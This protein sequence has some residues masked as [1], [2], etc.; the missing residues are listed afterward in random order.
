MSSNNAAPTLSATIQR[1]ASFPG[2]GPGEYQNASAFAIIKNNGSVVTWG[3]PAS[4]GDSSAVAGQLTGQIPV[5]QIVS[6]GSAFAALRN[7]GSVIT[8]GNPSIGGDS[9]AVSNSLSGNPP[10]TQLFSTGSAFAALRSDGSVVSWGMSGA[11]GDSSNIASQLNGSIAVTTIYSTNDAFAALRSDGSVVTWGNSADGGTASSQLTASIPVIRIF[12]TATAF[13][14]LRADGSVVT[15]GDSTSGGNNSSVSSQLTGTPPV[16]QVFS[17]ADAFAALRADGS[18]ITWG[19]TTDGGNSSTVSTQLNGSIPV[20]QVYATSD[21]FIALRSD[22]SIVSWGNTGNIP[23]T[24]PST[25]AAPFPAVTQIA[26]TTGAFAVLLANGSVMAWGSASSGGDTSTVASQLNG[27]IPVTQL[28]AT[29][30]AF[31]AVRADG[32]VITWGDANSGGDSSAVTNQVNSGVAAGPEGTADYNHPISYQIQNAPTLLMPDSAQ[33]TLSGS[34]LSQIDNYNGVS[35]TIARHGGANAQDIFAPS[36]T[37]RLAGSNINIGN[38]TLGTF[39]NKAGSLVLNF[40][41]NASQALVNA[42]LKQLTYQNTADTDTTSKTVL[43]DWTFSAKSAPVATIETTLTLLP[44]I[45]PVLNPATAPVLQG[46]AAN[47]G[48][49]VGQVGTLVSTLLGGGEPLNNYSD[50]E[51]HAPGMAIIGTAPGTLWYST[52]NGGTWLKVG[53]LTTSSALTLFADKNT[54]IYYQPPTGFYGAISA[55]ISFKA[56][57]QIYGESNGGLNINTLSSTAFSSATDT[58]AINVTA[59]QT[60]NVHLDTSFNGTGKVL[61]DFGSTDVA[62]AVLVQTD[63]KIVVAGYGDA[64]I[65]FAISRYNA[66]GSLDTSFAGTGMLTTDFGATDQ[67]NAIAQQADGKILLAGSTS[68]G[69]SSNFALVRYN[70]NGTLDQSFNHSG[71]V[72]TSFGS[73]TNAYANAMAVQA[74]NKIILAGAANNNFA[75]A[76]YNPDGSLD[77]SFNSTGLVTTNLN[78]LSQIRSVAIQSDGK[79]LVAGNDLNATG[80]EIAMARYNPD[81]SL[82][83]S[84]A[85]NGE[86]IINPSSTFNLFGT[87]FSGIE[88]MVL[89]PDGKILIAGYLQSGGSPAT[90]FAI[91]RLNAN[92][93]QDL[94]FN[95]I[96][97][98]TTDFGSSGSTAAN[99]HA[100]AMLLRPDGKIVVVGTTNNGNDMAVAQYLTNGSPDPSFNGSGQQT[101]NFGS[102]DY[103]YAIAEQTDGKIVLAGSG[104][105][106]SDFAIARL[107]YGTTVSYNGPSLSSASYNA[108]NGQLTLTGNKLT[109]GIN[110]YLVTDLT[111]KGDGNSSYTLTSGS[112]L[113]NISGN[114][115]ITLQLSAADQQAVNTLFNNNGVTADNGTPYNLS[116][117]SGWDTTANSVSILGVAVSNV[118]PPSLTTVSYN[119]STGVFNI[120]GSHL[121]NNGSNGINLSN[122]TL[123]TDGNS[124]YT[125]NSSQDSLSNLTANGFT[126]TL[127]TSD[128]AA[129]NAFVNANGG[130]ALSGVAYQ[131]NTTALWDNDSGAAI[132]S[133]P[134]TVNGISAALPS[135]SAANYNAATGILTLTGNNLTSTTAGYQLNDFTL[136]GDG[137]THYQLT[138]GHVIVGTATGTSVNLQL[139]S[140]DQLAINGLLNHN[141]SQAND[142][143]L[144]NLSASNGWDTGA[145]ALT[146]QGISVSNSSNTPTI[147]GVSYDASNGQFIFTGNHLTNHGNTSGINLSDF[148]LSNT[149]Y[150][151]F[152]PTYTVNNLTSTGFSFSL[153][154]ADQQFFNG[155]LNTAGINSNSGLSLMLNA[156]A[157]WDSNNGAAIS[158]QTITTINLNS[159]ATVSVSGQAGPWSP[160][161]NPTFNYGYYYLPPTKVYSGIGSLHFN[162]G[163]T[164]NIKYAGGLVNPGVGQGNDAGG[165]THGFD[166]RL[167]R[168]PAYFI[169]NGANLEELV[170]VFA[171]SNDVIV[172]TPFAIGNSAKVVIPTNASELLLGFND[173]LYSDNTGSINVSITESNN[174]NPPTLNSVSYNASNGVLTLTGN[175]ISTNTA[176]FTPTDL[177]L[178]GDGGVSYTLT[179]GSVVV[180]GSATTTSVNLQLSSI[181]Q[182]AINGLLNNNGNQAQ[183][184]THYLLTATNEWQTGAGAIINQPITVSNSTTPTLSKVSY[185]IAS[186]VLTF[187]GNHLVNQGIN[188]GI[189]DSYFT[190]QAGNSSYIFNS[191]D[192][193]SNLS[194]TGFTITLSSSDHA[195][196]N[197]FIDMN[198]TTNS[199]GN[200]YNLKTSAGWDSDSGN[201]VNT[202]GLTATGYVPTLTAANYDAATGKLTL[203]GSHLT[204]NASQYFVNAFTLKGDGSSSYTLSNTSTVS[205]APTLNSV[206]LQL[207][208][209]DQLALDGLFNKNGNQANDGK[210]SYNLSAI[211]G[212]DSGSSAI[213]TQSIS[214][215]NVTAPTISAVSYNTATGVFAFSGNHLVNHGSINGISLNNFKL[216]AG[217]SSYSFNS[218]DT[219][220]NLT[221]TGFSINLSKTDQTSVN[222]F[223]NNNGNQSLNGTSYN[224]SATANWDSDSGNAISTQTVNVSNLATLSTASYDANSGK[225]TLG[226]NYLTTTNSDYNFNALT[227]KGDGGSS[228]TLS[229]TS[230]IFGVPTSTSVTLQLSA[231]D[232]LAINGLLNKNGSQANDSSNYLLSSNAGWDTSASASSNQS[233]TVS[234]STSPTIT[235]VSYNAVT[236]IF[237]VN[238]SSFANHGNSNGIILSNFKFTGTSGSYSFSA[239]NDSVSNLSATGFNINLSSADKTSVNHLV[240]ANGL[241]P[242]TGAAYNLSATG[243]WDSDSGNAITTQA[244]SVNGLPTIAQASYDAASGR[245]SLSGNNFTAS[246]TDYQP[247]SLTLKGDGNSSYTL[248][249]GS[250]VFGT[251]SSSGVT[252]QLSSADQ[253]AINGLLNKSGTQANDGSTTYILNAGNGWDTGIGTAKS[254]ALTVSNAI[255][256][257]ITSVSYNTATGVFSFTG[258]NLSNHGSSNG[259]AVNHFALTGGTNGNYQFNASNDNVTNLSSSGFTITLNSTDKTAVNSFVNS[260]GTAPSTGAAYNLTATSNWDSD[261]GAGISS[262]PVTVSGLIPTINSVKYNA[263]NGLLTLNGLYLTTDS[264]QYVATDLTLKG[265]GNSSYTLT[266]GS[267]VAGVPTNTSVSIQLS[268]ADQLAINGLLNKSG[269]AANDG[270]IYSL[271]AGSG[272]DSSI[273][274]ANSQ[275]IS[276]SNTVAPTLTAVS[277]N[278]ASGVFSFTGNHL[279]NHGSSN[280]IA[281][282]NFSLTGGSNGNYQFN[283]T[284]DSVSNLS[285]TGFTITLSNADKTAVNSFVTVNGTAPLSGA[286]YNLNS[287]A[288][289]DS[290]NGASI[291]TQSVYV[292]GLLP[293]LSSAS[294]NAATGQLTLSGNNLTTASSNYLVTDFILKGDGN[295]SYTLSNSSTIS[296]TPTSTSLSIQLSVT[297]Q[298]AINGLFNKNGT[299]ANDGSSIY[300]L[301]TTIGWD[302]GANPITTLGIT[303]SNATTP[304]ITRLAYNAETGVFSFSGNNLTN[305]G[306]STGVAL[307]HFTVTAGNTGSYTFNSF[308]D[309]VSNLSSTGFT[310]TLNTSDQSTVNAL[311]NNNGNL[312][313]NSSAYNL[314]TT[315]KWDSDT[316][317]AIT[318]QG[319]SVTGATQTV[320]SSGIGI[321]SGLAIDSAGSLYLADS[322]NNAIEKIAAGSHTV[323]SLLNNG[324]SVPQG[325]AIDSA[326]NLYIADS[327][328]NAIK[329][330]VV[331][332]QTAIT[333]L[334]NGLNNPASIAVDT[335]GNIYIADTLNNAIKEISAGIH[336]VT[337]LPATGINVPDAIAVDNVGNVYFA[338]PQNKAIKEISALD[339]SVTTLLTTGLNRPQGIAVDN[340][341]N[342]F[343]T[344]SISNNIKEISAGSRTVTTVLAS[345]LANPTGIAVDSADNLYIADSNNRVIKELNHANYLFNTAPTNNNLVTINSLWENTQQIELSKSIFT[346]FANSNSIT[347]ANFSNSSSPTSAAD[348]LYYNAS[349]GGL[350]YAAQGSSNPGNAIEIAVVGVNSHPSALSIGDF[351]LLSSKTAPTLSKVSYNAATGQLTLTGAN[352]TN[353]ITDYNIA[354]LSLKGDGGGSY[355]LS[356]SSTITST[357]SSSTLSIQLSS[358]D[359]L[360]I[361]GLL[362]KNGNQAND[363]LSNYNLYAASGWDTGANTISN[364]SITVSNAATPSLSGVTYNATTGVFTVSGS[365]LDNHG[366]N[367][368]IAL[369]N[370]TL[371]AGSSSY[372]FNA[373]TDTITA[374]SNSSFSVTLSSADQL[375]INSFINHNGS[376]AGNG[377]AYNLSVS[378]NWD[379]DTGSLINTL[380]VWV[381]NV[382]LQTLI[383]S[384]LNSPQGITIDGSGNLYIADTL[385]NAIKELATGSQTLTNLITTGLNNP[386][387]IALDSAGNLY[388]ADTGNKVVEQFIPNTQTLTTIPDNILGSPQGIAVDSA[389]NIYVADPINNTIDEIAAGSNNS[390]TLA[391]S[392]LNNPQGVTVDSAGNVYIADTGNNAIEEIAAGSN[393]QTTLVNSG[394]FSPTSVAVDN[395][396]NLYIADQNGVEVFTTNTQSLLS[397]SDSRLKKAAAV[398][399]DNAGNLYIAD[400]GNNAIEEITHSALTAIPILTGVSY[401]ASS[402]VF[403]YTGSNL[404]SHNAL[405]LSH[406][407]VSLPLYNGGIAY[408]LAGYTFNTANDIVSNISNN[409]FSITLSS[410][411]QATVNAFINTNGTSNNGQSY[412]ISASANWD[413]GYGTAKSTLPLSVTGAAMQVLATNVSPYSLAVDNQGNIFFSDGTIQEI[414]A[415]SSSAPVLISAGS[416]SFNFIALDNQGNL[417]AD[418]FN[419]EIDTISATSHS[420]Q[421]ILYGSAYG[422]Y[423]YRLA[424]DTTGTL[425][426]AD[427][428]NDILE[429]K[430]GSHNINT[431]IASGAGTLGGIAVDNAGNIYFADSSNNSIS[432]IAAGTTTPQT[433]FASGLSTP[434]ALAMDSVGNL[435]VVDSGNNAIKEISAGNHVVTTLLSG[436]DSGTNVPMTISSIAVDSA[437]NVYIADTDNQQIKE[438]IHS[439]YVFNNAPSTT[440]INISQFWENTGQIEL[441][442]SV[443]SAFAGANSVSAAN[444]ANASTAQSPSDYLYYNAGTGGLYYNAGTSNPVEIAVI[445]VNSHPS[446]LSLGDFKLIA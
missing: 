160:A 59:I 310:V 306:S 298:L 242:Q 202:L 41:T 420:L 95:S 269:L 440:P 76:R 49:P 227:I 351:S 20:E 433:I 268:A 232:Q 445:G 69:S 397:L 130:I 408:G 402:G 27:S 234:N 33:I 424:T 126:L 438:I 288:N 42:A 132:N 264:H 252:F 230:S 67:G 9:S 198:G 382:A 430:H 367:I 164:L 214:V 170:G 423:P 15:W 366:S 300:N 380:G 443:F 156:T 149:S 228:Y 333:L 205:G 195:V 362:N 23:S 82:D 297:D 429:F 12:S 293:T 277:Y 388:I 35:L 179:S 368:G 442:K 355:T 114:H 209:G 106:N 369:N 86:L 199:S 399:L 425:Y 353:K 299:L 139:S 319:L 203:S 357:P 243:K 304:Q 112:K 99:A 236:G 396:G 305:H 163:D 191:H 45:S 172:G 404:L 257:T 258:N 323:S 147:T 19:N 337:T 2:H 250:Y 61:S 441:S 244:V 364:Q 276:V 175:H 255:A 208:V 322:G 286:A 134:V 256:P 225:L 274:V 138:G 83:T 341:G 28:Y 356:N 96:G 189:T 254:L 91:M 100:Y 109:T 5:L 415:G 166:F 85:S 115:S 53:T 385:N 263:A 192:Q 296:G 414:K 400:S 376:M 378:A 217:T 418:G 347:A 245:L 231:S 37:L 289:W 335:A 334:N 416:G 48:A 379:S 428:Y 93:T 336:N 338:D 321:I 295:T 201:A 253:L 98:V 240:N 249:S 387:A 51:N 312:S 301:S 241:N 350:Y 22:G 444:F 224:L 110:D 358:T 292:S 155:I 200:I 287:L 122:F 437:G 359:Q 204:L 11:G 123:S 196:V 39:S 284:N 177:T 294:Y 370:F 159:I 212:W 325:V 140:T 302:T 144:Y 221:A 248:S 406:F 119:A 282:N 108:D 239:S 393:S 133:L 73:N 265:D 77:S 46:V 157:N 43:M 389:G 152:K 403:S 193:V 285:S 290:N 346:A 411:D 281:V 246:N 436:N 6:T 8:W 291:S 229:N 103:G 55:A 58:A 339:H 32:S 143:S 68:N 30:N 24:L 97:L 173:N 412:S 413:G 52:N 135:L 381:N 303:V 311:L 127:N 329:E 184:S 279:S 317:N 1:M 361:N 426:V 344:D 118:I 169:P 34:S 29:G 14:A 151:P 50:S 182:L 280:G 434:T 226:G 4:G 154:S 417:Y 116:A 419:Q 90:D 183:D 394:L 194:S 410:S 266:S 439:T 216:N 146:T 44:N 409:G 330:I 342:V 18:V 107:S 117:S 129:V 262:Q 267:S 78:G 343:V 120:T 145:V 13:A 392:G 210:T 313:G 374:L 94:S 104:G 187:T 125:F 219:V 308:N 398:A 422:I 142:G 363:G 377:T 259:I 74:D 148:A 131:L 16:I 65:D 66:D 162:A 407:M 324:L 31:A 315:A 136:T 446:A 222:A 332:S 178:T 307:N 47:A 54:R 354:K 223:I 38:I 176:A 185:N 64:N 174:I 40:N 188:N 395:S 427:S 318:S 141:G 340:A 270:S 278:A 371:S 431:Q 206:T 401:N 7:D 215:S 207:S 247:T 89:Q 272:W 233:I 213:N 128:K 421:P 105:S 113:L 348:Y 384:G 391:V 111:L 63:N 62:R 251:P 190:L 360:A 36:G 220:N 352:L 316:G 161:L 17:T 167:G 81:G 237:S 320:V 365:N 309:K 327:S 435:Y 171:N 3:D 326:G 84:F 88:S 10:V 275:P 165:I 137:G 314:T 79:I 153:D 60:G 383:A 102:L 75:L 101:I 375:A 373:S 328:D 197:S 181:D 186:G 390:S 124:H 25:L 180:A 158:Q 26:S 271:N 345:G 72:T 235:A 150:N 21:A 386:Q 349:T 218:N 405:A 432:E 92:G 238:G 331:G 211:S 87:V 71:T 283:A 80:Y 56:M 260:N 273:S 121:I 372:T 261:S 168:S 70:S 57:Q